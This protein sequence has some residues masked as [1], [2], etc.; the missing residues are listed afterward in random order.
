MTEKE[1]IEIVHALESPKTYEVY[2]DKWSQEKMTFGEYAQL[3]VFGYN[4]LLNPDKYYFVKCSIC[5]L[6]KDLFGDGYFQSKKGNLLNGHVPCGCAKRP[7]WSAAQYKTKSE[8]KA[9]ELGY[10]FKGFSSK[11]MGN[12]TKLSLSCEVHG[13]WD[14]AMFSNFFD[15]GE[16][17]PSCGKE[18]APLA[19]RFTNEDMTKMCMNIGVFS[20]GTIFWREVKNNRLVNPGYWWV[21]C[22]RC[23]SIAE[24][25]H[26]N[27][28]KGARPCLC[29]PDHQREAYINLVKDESGGVVC[30]KF[31]IAVN[32]INRAKKQNRHS[33]YLVENY[34]TFSFPDVHSTKKAEK[35]CK[36]TLDC[37]FISKE[38]ML[39]GYTETTSKD[40]IG[41]IIEIYKAHGGT[42]KLIGEV[43]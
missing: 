4:G 5:S 1:N 12:K 27:L 18:C 41:K 37:R 28:L 43:K 30:V 39:D 11:F 33:F 10:I 22:P 29:A 35:V 23:G 16:G 20:T 19:R 38:F 17:C 13:E 24:S 34:L 7:S 26:G 14:S 8:R 6:D 2:Q 25:L 3:Q 21:Y 36:K 42:L 9:K 40:N 15:H 31:G 32:S